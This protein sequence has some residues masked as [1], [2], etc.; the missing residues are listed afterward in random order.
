MFC[1]KNKTASRTKAAPVALRTL[2][3]VCE[4]MWKCLEK[5]LGESRKAAG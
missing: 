3:L 2:E 5:G 1:N 4:R